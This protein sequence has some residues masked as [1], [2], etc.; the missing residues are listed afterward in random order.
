MMWLCLSELCES[1]SNNITQHIEGIFP[2]QHLNRIHTMC[3]DIFGNFSVSM[4]LCRRHVLFFVFIGV[5]YLKLAVG[6]AV[7][8]VRGKIVGLE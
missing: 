7:V 1:L 2:T 3:D 8:R 5:N 6:P 4:M